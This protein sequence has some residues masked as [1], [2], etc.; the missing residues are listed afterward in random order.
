MLGM[1]Q[2]RQKITAQKKSKKEFDCP[3]QRRY[4]QLEDRT[5]LTAQQ[6]DLP[7]LNCHRPSG[8]ASPLG[9]IVKYVPLPIGRRTRLIPRR[10]P[11]ASVRA[12]RV[13][14][15]VAEYELNIALIYRT[16]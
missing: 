1:Y 14:T 2:A 12:L 11:A 10:V 15:L 13:D 3:K 8:I 16:G 4:T 9:A 7:A 6:E 5:L